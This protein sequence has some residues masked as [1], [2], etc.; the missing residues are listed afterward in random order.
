MPPGK[1]RSHLCQ[2]VQDA[3]A[4]GFELGLVAA[5]SLG[6]Y[7]RGLGHGVCG[8]A[9]ADQADVSRGLVVEA[10]LREAGDE[11]GGHVYG[12]DALLG[13]DAGVRAAAGEAQLGAET[14]GRGHGDLVH[15]TLAVEL[16]AAPRRDHRVIQICRT[17]QAALLPTGEDQL[18]RGQGLARLLEGGNAFKDGRDAGLGVAAEDGRAVGVDQVAID[19]GLNA[20]AGLDSV[21][22]GAEEEGLAAVAYAGDDVAVSVLPHVRAERLQAAA[23]VMREGLLLPGGTVDAHEVEKSR[24]EAVA[25]DHLGPSVMRISG[26]FYSRRAVG[27]RLFGRFNALLY[28]PHVLVYDSTADEGHEHGADYSVDGVAACHRGGFFEQG[29]FAFGLYLDDVPE[30]A[31]V[32]VSFEDDSARRVQL[33]DAQPCVVLAHHRRCRVVPGTDV[34]WLIALR[35]DG[36]RVRRPLGVAG[37]V[38]DVREDRLGGRVDLDLASQSWHAFPPSERVGEE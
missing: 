22:V 5:A 24:E 18:Q 19:Q 9:A 27:E 2:E 21:H 37:K 3:L 10:A 8:C 28:P 31:G 23:Q 15:G 16:G 35:L 25:V 20:A 7:A 33:H 1:A 12:R 13:L 14:A 38:G 11:T 34:G 26:S 6:G 36:E 29:A 17:F 32:V 4:Q 30:L